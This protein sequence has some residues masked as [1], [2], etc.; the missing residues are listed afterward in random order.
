MTPRVPSL[1]VVR[2]TWLDAAHRDTATCVDDLRAQATVGVLCCSVGWLVRD[3]DNGVVLAGELSTTGD[4]PRMVVEIPRSL[5][6][7]KVRR[8]A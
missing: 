6:Q 4:D 2:V 3:D 5:I 1:H 7:G 8:L